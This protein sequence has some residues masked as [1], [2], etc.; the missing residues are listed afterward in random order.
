[1]NPSVAGA[2]GFM[3]VVFEHRPAAE[4]LMTNL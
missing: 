2:S 1:M 3:I 4:L